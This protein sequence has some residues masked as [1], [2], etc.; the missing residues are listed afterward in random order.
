MH[1]EVTGKKDRYDLYQL[2]RTGNYKHTHKK[3]M[4]KLYH[5]EKNKKNYAQDTIFFDLS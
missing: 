2:H 4:A 3:R 1:K 5:I